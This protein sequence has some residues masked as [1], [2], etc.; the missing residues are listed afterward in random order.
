[1]QLI[2]DSSYCKK[3]STILPPTNADF[4]SLQ[5]RDG[6]VAILTDCGNLELFRKEPVP[7]VVLQTNIYSGTSD[8]GPS[9]IGTTSLQRTLVAAPCQYFSVL[10]YLRD[11][12]SLST[13]DTRF[14][15]CLFLPP[16]KGQPLNNM[17]V[18]N[19]SIIRRFHCISRVGCLIIGLIIYKGRKED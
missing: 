18:P 19:V 10:F 15:L 6:V 17:L 5:K 3:T 16:K 14:T 7:I 11:R 8:K 12:D 13:R 2:T 9:E 4:S 1:M